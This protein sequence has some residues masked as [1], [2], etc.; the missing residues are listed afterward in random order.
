MG[1]VATVV[2]A[3]VLLV[4]AVFAGGYVWQYLVDQYR[5]IKSGGRR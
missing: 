3:I 5:G 2:G 4:A 1:G